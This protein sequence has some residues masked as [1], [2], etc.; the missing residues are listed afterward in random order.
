[1]SKAP[2]AL[3]R[4]IRRNQTQE[5]TD[6][7]GEH[8]VR[9]LKIVTLTRKTSQCTRNIECNRGL[10]SN[11]QSFSHSYPETANPKCTCAIKAL[12]MRSADH[13]STT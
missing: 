10:L 3:D 7:R 5:V 12:A 11:N 4:I 1:M 6:T 9:I 13:K 2:L 8:K